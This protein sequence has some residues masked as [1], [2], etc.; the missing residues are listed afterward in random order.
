MEP[1]ERLYAAPLTG[2]NE[3][4]QNRRCSAAVIAAEKR[5]VATAQRDVPIGSFA[6]AIVDFQLA[7]LQKARQRLPLIQRITH[8][9]PGRTLRKNILLQLQQILMKPLHQ[10]DRNALT[11]GQSLLR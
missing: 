10:P 2:R 9:G 3:A 7:I 1:G 4:S 8:S 11:Q 5:P 6:G